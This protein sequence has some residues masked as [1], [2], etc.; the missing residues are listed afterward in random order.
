MDNPNKCNEVTVV[1]VKILST[2]FPHHEYSM[3]K[4]DEMTVACPPGHDVL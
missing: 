3:V 1:L 4:L 2:V